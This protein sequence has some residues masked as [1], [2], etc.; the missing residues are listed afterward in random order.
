MIPEPPVSNYES[1]RCTL[2]YAMRILIAHAK[3]QRSGGEDSVYE[4]EATQL[5]N[6]GYTVARF[7]LANSEINVASI[8]DKIDMGIDTIWSRKPAISFTKAL[9]KSRASLVHFHNTFPLISPRA[10]Y[11]CAQANIPCIQTLHNY[12]MMCA[13]AT[14]Y[15]AG[16]VCELCANGSFINGI[17]HR[18]YRSSRLATTAVVGMQYIHH[19]FGT[20]RRKVNRFI[21]L[22]EFSRKKFIANGIPESKIITKPNSLAADPE[23]GCGKRDFALFAGRLTHEKGVRTLLA[24]WRAVP[25]FALKIVGDGPLLGDVRRIAAEIGPRVEICGERTR[26]EVLTLMGDAAV[27]IVPSEW[28]EGFPMTVIESFAKGTPVVAAKIGSLAEIVEDRVVGWHFTPGKASELAQLMNQILC[29]LPTLR[30]IG[31]AARQRYRDRYT[32]EKNVKA[33]KEIYNQVVA[34]HQTASVK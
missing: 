27:T 5:E 34:E 13:N 33:L 7:E 1:N 17:V 2:R 30:R 23:I 6:A 22:T 20:Y 8:F 4:A 24:A 10:Y 3:Y 31:A 32:A 29:D 14:F 28:Y 9:L 16:K 19:A 15:R 12:R 25:D 21:A 18:C 11:L 26:S